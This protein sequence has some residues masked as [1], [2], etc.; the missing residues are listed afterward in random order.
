MKPWRLLPHDPA[1]I[2]RLAAALGL[3]P[4]TAQLLLNRGL[5]SAEDARRFLDAPLSG[6][7]AR[8]FCRA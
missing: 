2:G 5:T 3:A 6:L 7:H 8:N 4:I 1:A